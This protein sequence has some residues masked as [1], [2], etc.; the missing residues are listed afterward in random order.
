MVWVVGVRERGGEEVSWEH[1][2]DQKGVT[3]ILSQV[4]LMNTYIT[5]VTIK[6]NTINCSMNI[7]NSHP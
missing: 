7:I 6:M 5:M 4:V 1:L 3:Y 2:M